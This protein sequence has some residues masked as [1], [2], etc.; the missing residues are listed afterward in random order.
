MSEQM[1]AVNVNLN[2]LKD[3]V[4]E[5]GEDVFMSVA[6]YKILPALYSQT[7]K[8]ALVARP[9]LQC[10]NCLAVKGVDEI[11]NGG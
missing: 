6:Q 7:G 11:V 9:C 1:Q 3:V 10:S 2:D 4:C 5:C 8:P